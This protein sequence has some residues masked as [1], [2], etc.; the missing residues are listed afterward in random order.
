MNDFKRYF[1]RQIARQH[2]IAEIKSKLRDASRK[3]DHD[4]VR[5]IFMSNPELLPDLK[6]EDFLTY[7][8]GA[9]YDNVQS[10]VIDGVKP[11]M[12]YGAMLTI[13]RWRAV[14]WVYDALQHVRISLT[15]SLLAARQPGFEAYMLRRIEW[16]SMW[17]SGGGQAIERR[18]AMIPAQDFNW[19][20]KVGMSLENLC[21]ACNTHCSSK[22]LHWA[23]YIK[24][25]KRELIE[26]AGM[27]Q[28][29]YARLFERQYVNGP[30]IE[31]VLWRHKP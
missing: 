13:D 28:R 31:Y 12:H 4:T 8:Y 11:I 15:L 25:S 22:R 9:S 19:L 6:F 3:G 18:P 30:F 14:K 2:E 1:Q 23:Y 20:F 16:L 7:R 24:E 21:M 27:L 5:D 17:I 29:S 26:A 10:K